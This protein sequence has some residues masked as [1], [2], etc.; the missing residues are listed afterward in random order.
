M[1]QQRRLEPGQL[2]SSHRQ[3]Y[4]VSLPGFLVDEDIGLGDALKRL[5]YFVGMSPCG[6]CENRAETLNRWVHF[7]SNRPNRE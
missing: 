7:T 2:A 6:G 5:T 3:P 1:N 4:R